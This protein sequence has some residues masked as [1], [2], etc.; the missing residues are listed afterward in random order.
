MT[1]S[2]LRRM[3]VFAA[4]LAAVLALIAP[5]YAPSSTPTALA[6]PGDATQV[7]TS[8]AEQGMV[9]ITTTVD[10]Q[11]V[12]G[13]GAGIVVSPDGAVLTNNH[14]VSGADRITAISVG[15]GQKFSAQLLG[16]DRTND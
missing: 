14:V 12:V 11:G 5:V 6:E 3:A 1:T 15:T 13:A 10:Y 4:V 2:Q 9:Q 7:G 16:Y 8:G